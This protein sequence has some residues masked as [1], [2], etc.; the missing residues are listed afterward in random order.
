MRARKE[1]TMTRHLLKWLVILPLLALLVVL[2]AS[3]ILAADLRGG[4][5]VIIAS[6][7]VIDDDLYIAAGQVV[8]NGTV[9][10]DVLCVGETISVNGKINGSVTAVGG[11]VNIDGEVT[12]AVRVAGQTV[13]IRGSV[14]RDVVVAGDDISMART[15]KI[16]RDLVFAVRKIRVDAMIEDSIKGVG[17]TAALSTGVGG[18]VE[19]G[20]ETLTIESTANIQG[21]LIYTSKNEAAIQSGARIGGTTTH[22]IPETKMPAFPWSAGIWM[23]VIAF[24]MTLVFGGLIILIAPRRAT[25][26]A[27]S[28]RQRP[29]LSLGWGAIIL[30]AAPVAA[31]VAFITIVGVPVG[32]IGLVAYGVAIYLSQ[33]AVGLFIGYWIIGYFSKVDSRGMLLGAFALGFSILTLVKLIPYLG[34]P[35]WL[36]TVLFGIGAMVLSQKTMSAVAPGKAPEAIIT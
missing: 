24:L 28:I 1:L 3:P 30:F 7:D 33:V 31:V 36:A 15:A 22:K 12:N 5:A 27:A 32:V 20:I 23:R 34:F 16:G 26:V 14:G 9:N 35:L 4:D 10:G 2:P 19:I 6:G 8:I 25:A 29:W 18:N 21:N 11:T 13:A 17:S